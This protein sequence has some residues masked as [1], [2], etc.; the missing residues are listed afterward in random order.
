MDESARGTLVGWLCH[1]GSVLLFVRA[2]LATVFYLLY[3][4]IKSV[5]RHMHQSHKIKYDTLV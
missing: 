3:E 1:A 5:L 2:Q 4:Y